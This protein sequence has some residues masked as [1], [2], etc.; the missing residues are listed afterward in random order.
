MYDLINSTREK[1]GLNKLSYDKENAH[2]S[3]KMHAYDMMVNNY[4]AHDNLKGETPFD[5]MDMCGVEYTLGG[6]NLAGGQFS[7]IYAHEAL[8]NSE[9]HRKNILNAYYNSIG[10]GI[11]F[12]G[13][14][15]TYYVENFYRN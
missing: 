1:H 2:N 12:G 4:F 7:P 15:D 10:I 9:G 14:L 11:E 8:M 6:E 3:A 13:E 5:R